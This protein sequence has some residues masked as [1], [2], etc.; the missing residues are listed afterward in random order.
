MKR[1]S[2]LKIFW[3]TFFIHAT[4][5]FRRMQNLGFA[6]AMIPLLQRRKIPDKEVEGVLVRQL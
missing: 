4:L 3:R 5:N 6:Y 1:G 2:L